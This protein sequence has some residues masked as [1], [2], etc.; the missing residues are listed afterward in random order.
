[1]GTLHYI[2]YLTAF[3]KICRPGANLGKG[4]PDLISFSLISDQ[5][6]SWVKN[7]ARSGW[8]IVPRIFP[9]ADV[10]MAIS[11]VEPLGFGIRF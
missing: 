7:I 6:G 4:L 8:G 5:L 9:S 11:K 10:S 2:K 3:L 1:M